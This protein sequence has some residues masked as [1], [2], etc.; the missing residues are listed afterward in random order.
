MM[1]SF[2]T[3]LLACLITF[4][5]FV[6]VIL[7]ISLGHILFESTSRGYASYYILG[8]MVVGSSFF[9]F[10][11]ILSL[12]CSFACITRFS[13]WIYV[14]AGRYIIWIGF[15]QDHDGLWLTIYDKYE[16]EIRVI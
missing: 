2:V 13:S 4:F 9:F 7:A 12:S 3:N 10:I 15:E 5:F 8:I 1:V 14:Y 11:L 6:L 16:M